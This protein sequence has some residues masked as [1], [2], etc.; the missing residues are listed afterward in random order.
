MDKENIEKTINDLVDDYITNDG[1]PTG[2]YQGILE[3]VEI[4]T[5]IPYEKLNKM[6][7]DKLEEKQNYLDADTDNMTDGQLADYLAQQ[8]FQECK[9]G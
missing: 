1:I 7:Q 9:N 8:E 6:F 2:D 3:A 4:K 5:N